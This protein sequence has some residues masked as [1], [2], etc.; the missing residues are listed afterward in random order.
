MNAKAS[1]WVAS[2]A[3]AASLVVSVSFGESPVPEL[4]LGDDAC[5]DGDTC[6]SQC[7][8]QL[9]ACA[10]EVTKELKVRKCYQCCKEKEKDYTETYQAFHEGKQPPFDDLQENV[11]NECIM[12]PFRRVEATFS[13]GFPPSYQGAKA[14]SEKDGKTITKA[15]Q[16]HAGSVGTDQPD[17]I[18]RS[19]ETACIKACS[20][21]PKAGMDRC[22]AA[23]DACRRKCPA[24]K[25]GSCNN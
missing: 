23:N 22:R 14:W 21:R 13:G 9:A 1:R 17:A 3:F 2:L 18:H 20:H 10:R 16:A 4:G 15:V 12:S 25:K 6:N 8:A 5:A 7:D 24:A 11:F 19:D